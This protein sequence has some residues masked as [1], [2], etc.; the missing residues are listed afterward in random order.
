MCHIVPPR[1]CPELYAVT[2]NPSNGAE[3]A[4][5]V[6]WWGCEY[7]RGVIKEKNLVISAAEGGC[8]RM[9]DRPFA[10]AGTSSG[11]TLLGMTV[12]ANGLE[13]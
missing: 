10:V 7:L 5:A 6:G 9:F 2:V 13:L 8:L 12:A 11:E 3:N 4:E 1:V